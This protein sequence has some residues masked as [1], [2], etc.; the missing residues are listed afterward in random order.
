MAV[1]SR[2]DLASRH[3]SIGRIAGAH[4]WSYR[5]RQ[6][7][8]HQNREHTPECQ[9]R[10]TIHA[11]DAYVSLSVQHCLVLNALKE[12]THDFGVRCTATLDF[13]GCT[14]PRV[15]GLET[16]FRVPGAETSRETDPT[17]ILSDRVL[18]G[19]MLGAFTRAAAPPR[20]PEGVELRKRAA[21][22]GPQAP[23]SSVHT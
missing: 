6:S 1:E 12:A 20:T 3:G 19:S 4:S 7:Y 18:Q 21:A 14:S 22:Q 13:N 11:V 9:H 2:G 23:G 10:L 8:L 17:G 15:T 16:S 5:C